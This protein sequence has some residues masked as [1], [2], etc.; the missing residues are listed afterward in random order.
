[1]AYYSLLK[2]YKPS[3]HRLVKETET[4]IHIN[5]KGMEIPGTECVYLKPHSTLKS[6]GIIIFEDGRTIT[7]RLMFIS[8]GL[9][10]EKCPTT[11][12]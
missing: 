2:Y 1:M 8:N 4:E 9:Y 7:V 10:F 11:D 5:A 12:S 3:Y 6:H